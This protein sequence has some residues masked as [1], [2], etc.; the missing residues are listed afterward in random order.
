MG[1]QWRIEKSIKNRKINKESRNQD[2]RKIKKKIM[3]EW[4]NQ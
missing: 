2:S 4:G 1:N 3:K